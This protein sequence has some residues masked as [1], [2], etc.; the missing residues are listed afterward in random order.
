MH[1]FVFFDKVMAPGLALRGPEGSMV[2]A[3]EGT[4]R[5]MEYIFAC[6]GLSVVT[7][8]ISSV[9]LAWAQMNT[10]PACECPLYRGVTNYFVLFMGCALCICFTAVVTVVLSSALVWL[11]AT[12]I[13]LYKRF[14]VPINKD[15]VT[16]GVQV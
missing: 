4:K 3:V 11:G 13:R 7:M 2:R 14:A 6:G 8:F 16:E 5:E 9:M 12:G 1:F 15:F 10:G